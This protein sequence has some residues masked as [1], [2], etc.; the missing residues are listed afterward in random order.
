MN[1]DLGKEA[2]HF[3]DFLAAS[4]VGVWQML[5]IG[6]VQDDGSPYQTTSVFAGDYRL[7]SPEMA[8]EERWIDSYPLDERPMTDDGRRFALSLA[9]EGFKQRASAQFRTAFAQFREEHASWLGD[10]ALFQAL[11]SELKAPW[12]DWPVKLRARKPKALAEARNRLQD[13][14]AYLEFEQFLF[15]TQWD[16]LKR[17]ARAKGIIL[18]GDI[19][20]FVAQDSAEVWATPHYFDLL[21]NGLPR[22]VAGVPPDYFSATGQ[23]WGNPLYRWDML[24][25]D[26]F[27][28]WIE[29]I[30]MQLKLFDVV[31]ID[32]F[33]GFEAYWEIPAEDPVAINGRWVKAPGE[34]LFETLF[35][36]FGD[37][38]LVA[39]DLGIITPEVE[40]LRQRFQLPGMKILQFAFSGESQNPYLPCNHTPDSVVYTG[41]HDNDTTCG[42]YHGLSDRE[43]SYLYEIL[44]YPRE[45]I[46]WVLIRAAFASVAHWAIIPMQD[47]L[48]LGSEQRMNRPGTTAGNWR[49]RFH[50]QQVPGDL[51]GRLH[52]LIALYG[53]R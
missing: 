7:I 38:P 52:H 29:R 27:S 53:R 42:W 24:Q 12:W 50:W 17:A 8:L 5:P 1:G 33:R 37:L 16:R 2:F 45:D 20:I 35:A 11:H 15:F 36:T 49:W 19:P 13:T 34:A 22:V 51:A 41:T 14:I 30:R 23:R 9:W 6:P 44:G 18:F 46:P 32:H 31:R 47:L 40:Q 39:E 43:R 48:A 3:L 21:P 4:G 28:F 10:Y 26:G 25:K